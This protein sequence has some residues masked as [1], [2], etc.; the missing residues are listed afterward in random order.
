[1][2]RSKSDFG[3]SPLPEGPRL[4]EAP[5]QV[6]VSE[7]QEKGLPSVIDQDLQGTPNFPAETDMEV[8]TRYILQGSYYDTGPK[9]FL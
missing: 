3:P 8:V 2:E 6:Y 5:Q 9:I 7:S 1:M 4:G